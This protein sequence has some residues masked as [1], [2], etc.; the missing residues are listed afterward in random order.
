MFKAEVFDRLL[1]G[2]EQFLRAQAAGSIRV[3]YSEGYASI[4]NYMHAFLIDLDIN[5]GKNHKRILDLF[6]QNSNS[7]IEDCGLTENMLE[8]Y[9]KTWLDIRYSHEKDIIP[10]QTVDFINYTR[11]LIANI[12]NQICTRNNKN[13]EDL[14]NE[15]YKKL[16]SA[17]WLTFEKECG[18]VHEMWQQRLEAAG[19]MGRGSK[20]GNKLTNPSNFSEVY[21]TADDEI[22]RKIL[23]EDDK[24]GYAIGKLY[25]SFL[26]IINS[27]IFKRKEL[28]IEDNELTNYFLTIKFRYHG[29]TIEEIGE[30][31]LK[32]ILKVINE[33]PEKNLQKSKIDKNLDTS[34]D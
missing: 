7:I 26:N 2:F 6:I 18:L 28:G 5:P 1:I 10:K 30:Y 31:F 13:P 24:I 32:P 25:N 29:M 27:L 22:T 33:N 11:S 12:Q 9:Y 34:S 3:A 17:R 21:A 15:I 4:D 20:L 19:E 8:D 14:E 23:A 16:M